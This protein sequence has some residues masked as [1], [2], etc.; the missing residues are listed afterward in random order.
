M[1][2]FKVT[3]ER[4]FHLL[5]LASQSSNR[6]LRDIADQLVSTGQLSAD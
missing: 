6:K 4:A 1:E 5:M 3:A 2:R